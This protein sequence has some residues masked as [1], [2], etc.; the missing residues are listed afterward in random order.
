MT[1]SGPVL[2]MYVGDLKP[3]LVVTITDNGQPL[4]LA[5]A[6]AVRVIG[7]FRG[8]TPKFDRAATSYTSG[9]V[10]TME[11]Q[12][13]DTDT[14]GDLLVEVEIMWPGSKAQTVRCDRGVRIR[15]DLGGT[16]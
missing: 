3:D 1:T 9:G 14:A 15:D 13:G 11:W 16:A 2:I 12:A 4:S 5:T 10:I 7:S 8:A 6:A